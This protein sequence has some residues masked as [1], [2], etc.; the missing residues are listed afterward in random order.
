M[1][2]RASGGAPGSGH[3][4]RVPTGHPSPQ[5]PEPLAGG[6]FREGACGVAAREA[7]PFDWA[8]GRPVEGLRRREPHQDDGSPGGRVPV[9]PPRRGSGQV[10]SPRAPG[11]LRPDPPLRAPRLEPVERLANRGRRAKLARCRALLAAVPP[12]TPAGPEPVVPLLFRLTG[13]DIAQCP[14]CDAGR[15]QVVA[16]FGPGHLPAP[17][18]DTS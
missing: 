14:V 6:R 10:S 8:H 4:S 1:F 5:R 18:L 13:V 16:I 12:P 2:W 9:P 7:L 15:L 11:R 3:G 17:A